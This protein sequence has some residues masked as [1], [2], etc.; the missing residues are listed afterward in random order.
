MSDPTHLQINPSLD[1][2]GE[3]L[4]RLRSLLRHRHG[5]TDLLFLSLQISGFLDWVTV[6]SFIV[7]RI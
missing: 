3:M 6:Y 7:K 1:Y 4:L 2:T 5:V